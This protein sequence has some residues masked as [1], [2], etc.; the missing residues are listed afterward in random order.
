[1]KITFDQL[2]SALKASGIIYEDK[3]K[4]LTGYL[5]YV[6]LTEYLYETVEEINKEM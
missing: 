6:D 3:G 1:M 4:L 2:V 5:E